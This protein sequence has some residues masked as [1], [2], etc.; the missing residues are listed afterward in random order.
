MTSTIERSRGVV[1]V[2]ALRTG[3]DSGAP[4][5]GTATP[6]LS[7]ALSGATDGVRQR[8][9]E[10]EL[11]KSETP[12]DWLS[13]GIL[14]GHQVHRRPWPF[15]P[16]AGK[17][18]RWVRVR[19]R[20]TTGWTEWSE[21]LRVETALLA[22]ADWGAAHLIGLRTGDT[23]TQPGRVV[24]YTKRVE[25]PA[26][27]RAL[28]H[29]TGLGVVRAQINGV[30]VGDDLLEPGWTSYRHR[31]LYSTYDITQ[32]LRHG[33]NEISLLVGDGWYRGKLTWREC[34]NVFG[35]RTAA[36]A[37][38]RVWVGEGRE[39]TVPTDSTWTAHATD[40]VF[41]DL[42]DGV[43]LE[44]GGADEHA[45]PVEIVDRGTDFALIQR[46][47][48]GVRV[49][50]RTYI[51]P[52]P[53]PRGTVLIDAGANI[54]GHVRL[55]LAGRAGDRVE[56]AHAEVLEP[57]GRLHTASLRTARAR[58]C[59]V[60]DSSDVVDLEPSFT[61]HGFRFAEVSGPGPL[62][63]CEAEVVTVASALRRTGWFV[64]SDARLNR[65]Y[66]NVLRSQQGNFLAIPTDCP[67]R[68]ERLGWTGDIQVFAPTAAMN[69]DVRGFLASWL[70]DLA[71]D[72]RKDGAVPHV[73][74]DVL[75]DVGS[76][77]WGD[78]A[79]L[80]PWALYEA[81][82]DQELL[83]RQF[84]TMRRWVDWCAV[85]RDEDGVWTGDEHFGDWLD[86]NGSPDRPQ[87]ATTDSD[88]IASAYLSYSARV[89]GLIGTILERT[90]DAERFTALADEVAIATWRR[91]ADDA[92]RTQTG[93]ALALEFGIVPGA[94]RDD[95]A[96]RLADLVNSSG[97]RIGTG[98]LGT[99]L[100]LPA[101]SSAGRFDQAFQLLFNEECPGWLYQVAQDATTMWERWDA[102]RPDGSIHAGPLDHPDGDS[103][104]SFNH[105]A[106]GCV[107]GWL[108][109]TIAGIA[110]TVDDPGYAT[111]DFAPVPPEQLSFAHAR[112]HTPLGMSG[113]NWRRSG[114]DGLV[115]SLTIAPGSQGRFRTP[116]G[117]D[118]D[119]ADG[120]VP[121][122]AAEADWAFAS[123]PSGAH[124]L[125]LIRHDHAPAGIR[126]EADA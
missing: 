69:A 58:D 67:Q 20:V 71:L 85:R 6:V 123:I 78:A 33:Y 109:R 12:G 75:G 66:D 80:V 77:G 118:V 89:V 43:N 13:S 84:D 48:A 74:P 101:L 63:L 53:T 1:L 64:C 61:F 24:R 32:H 81:Y 26:P 106:Y 96:D 41:A 86:P 56:V 121:T 87:L 3:D 55:R 120:L 5:I 29:L 82:G 76:T 42:Y 25:L 117:W 9:Y 47:F 16:M 110:P 4:T 73:V 8:E 21:P 18:V 36:L 72:Q 105:Y 23:L 17:T 92:R 65:L 46:D 98:F 45:H 111:I 10:V 28:L 95:V 50:Q 104:L 115:V 11:S 2:T 122:T 97:G 113:I 51:T 30:P 102:I 35:D 124:E 44:R 99:P 19:S 60:L 54:T 15:Q 7:W 126:K 68:D 94:E 39:L 116:P 22:E 93:C 119:Y 79:V 37:L 103:M 91:W 62:D 40:V 38:A 27:V 88:Y 49:L 83:S 34:R 125:R 70:E 107:G 14:L 52:V 112:V 108:Y 90:A 31:L 114:A 59:Y 100:V 57:D